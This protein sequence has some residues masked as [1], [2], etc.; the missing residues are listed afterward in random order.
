MGLI[1][2][3]VTTYTSQSQTMGYSSDGSGQWI[4][5]CDPLPEL[6]LS[7]SLSLSLCLIEFWSTSFR[8]EF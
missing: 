6:S 8:L 2:N 1:S 4:A 3:N 5:V 7:L